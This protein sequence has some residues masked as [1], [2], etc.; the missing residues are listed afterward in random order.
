MKDVNLVKIGSDG[1]S[2]EN[3]ERILKDAQ[4]WE[5]ET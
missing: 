4:K 3:I 1:V 2:K 5:Q